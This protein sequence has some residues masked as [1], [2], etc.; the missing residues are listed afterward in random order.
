M[1]HFNE[2]MYHR[3]TLQLDSVAPSQSM[4]MGALK[5]QICQNTSSEARKLGKITHAKCFWNTLKKQEDLLKQYPSNT[6]LQGQQWNVRGS[7]L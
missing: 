3:E 1:S 5:M 2:T 7:S 4:E 6:S